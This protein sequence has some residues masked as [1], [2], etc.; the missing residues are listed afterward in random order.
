MKK[1]LI[2]L[3]SA[4]V[5]MLGG[6]S[7]YTAT[8]LTSASSTGTSASVATRGWQAAAPAKKDI[9]V[10]RASRVFTPEKGVEGMQKYIVRFDEEP[11]AMY[12]GDIPGLAATRASMTRKAG[13]RDAA[14]LDM[15][16]PAAEA[17]MSYLHDRHV[18]ME[19]KMNLQVGRKME[20]VYNYR[21]ALNGMTVRMTQDEAMELAKVPGIAKIQR[22][23]EGFLTT[24]R[25]PTYIGAPQIWD[26]SAT[27]L[28]AMG[29]GIVIGMMD[30]GINGDHPSFATIGADGYVHTN[31]LGDG[32]FLGECD[33]TSD[34]FNPEVVCTNK[35]IG[36]YLFIDANPTE[37]SSEDTDGHGTHTSSTAGGN[38]TRATVFDAEGSPTGLEL[39]ISGV[40]P[41]A[42]I[43]TFQVCAP[44]C[45][46][47]DRVAA[48]EQIISDGLV[49]V[50][51]HSIG[52][53]TPINSSP[54]EDAM[55]LSFLS[56]R[57][58]GITVA[59]SAGNNGPDA[60]TLGSPGAPW[61]THSGAFTHD[62]E[63]STKF[64]T[65]MTGGLSAPSDI[66][67][68]AVTGGYGP[69]P[70][71]YAG[72]FD[73]GDADPAQ[74][75][76]PFPAGTF[77]GE[78]VMCDRGAIARV[79]KC[80]NVRDGGAGG[81]I[82]ANVAGGSDSLNNDAHVLPAIHIDIAAGNAVRDWLAEGTD[83]TAIISS[84]L[85][86][87]GSNAA[88]AA[89]AA[90]F[91]SRGPNLSQ[92]YL[93]ITVGSPGVDVY[94][95]FRNGIEF[96]FLSG[97]SM[98]SPHTAGSSVLLKQL[99]PD[100]T[101]AEILSALATTASVAAMKEDGVTPADPFDVGGGMVQVAE[102]A[103]A[104]LLLDETVA[105][106]QAAD[107]A[108][109]GDPKALNLPGMVN[110]ECLI[111]CSWT[112]TFE[113][114]Q[115]GS[116]TVSASAANITV[117]PTTF[118]LV[119]GE[120]QTI[121]INVDASALAEGVW[122]HETVNLVPSSAALPEQHLTVSVLPAAGQIPDIIQATAVRNADS[123]VVEDITSIAI[124]DLQVSVSGLAPASEETFE[125]LGDS[126]NSSP[127]DDLTD[128]V[129]FSLLSVPAD[130]DLLV[131]FT[132]DETSE[133]PDL[134]LYVGLD[135]DGDGLPSAGELVC[136]SA[137]A[138]AS[139]TC[140]VDEPTEGTWWV[141]VQNW[142]ASA[143]PP[144]SFVLSTAVSAGDAGNL[145]VDAPF[146]VPALEPFDLRIIWNLPETAQPGDLFF[147][148]I[149]IGSD[150]DNPDNFGT[151]PVIITRGE[152][153][154]TF[155]AS[156]DIAEVGDSIAFSA[157]IQPNFTTE[158]R[159]YEITAAIPPGF[160]VV[161]GSVTEGGV[162]SGDSIV[163]TVEMPSL[164][165]AE[166]SYVAVTSEEDPA[167]AI[168]FA[169]S[170]AYTDLEAFGIF[171]DTTIVGDSVTFNAFPGQNFNFYG[172]SFVGGL[173]LTDDGF[174]FFESTAGPSPFI[175][176]AIPSS[177]EPNDLIAA[178]WRDMIIP[179]PSA[180]PGAVV[181]VSLATAGPD[182]TLIEFDNMEIWPGGL[183]DSI[184]FAVAI[185]GV[186]DDTP[187]VYEIMTAFD[188]VNV[189]ET[190]GT[191]GVEN[192]TGTAGTQVFFEDIAV[193]SGM[194]ICYDLVQ[195]PSD[196][197]VLSYELTVDPVAV[198]T[199]VVATLTSEVD[200]IG[201]EAVTLEAPISVEG[202][203]LP[204]F[205]G[206]FQ[207]SITST[208]PILRGLPILVEFELFDNG[209]ITTEPDLTFVVVD[210]D[211]DVVYTASGKTFRF[212]DTY[213]RL[214]P[215][216]RL[217]VGD[218]TIKA[219]VDDIVVAEE[220]FTIRKFKFFF[221]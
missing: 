198:G 117:S 127:F 64:M 17:Y 7:A 97:T 60:S 115:A 65:D 203:P 215:T 50:I 140:N 53:N 193:T 201:T 80:I 99:H 44:G 108:L 24:D 71:V 72:D 47:S 214:M 103:K 221:W 82:L 109:G 129:V 62:R 196:S 52:S 83:H 105:N 94:A 156:T 148:A 12:E 160:S 172:R 143:N 9:S 194:A 163:W 174:I 55:A 11:L 6:I 153:D 54:W 34:L 216:G 38:F 132:E 188:N 147:G 19:D 192:Q 100:W 157:E 155:T 78:I 154:V 191:I 166:P 86:Q 170:G 145:T 197:V 138:T 114:T 142:Q 151:I 57:A 95:A 178:L 171:P 70:V 84:N 136:V 199:D 144:D 87:F 137:S 141:L 31:P 165:N 89:I 56:A 1:Q 8:T 176:E 121:T 41:H 67:G 79:D 205:T 18:E 131:A 207:G 177:T 23:Y 96:S 150:A 173:S 133:S 13:N 168:P 128:G 189:T 116:W 51:N 68:R 69:A 59:N 39:N 22:D 104:G 88:N 85:Q 120:M 32:V 76:V 202:E 3:A 161:D 126:D 125:L 139:E 73:N 164:A 179:T 206:E 149:T 10:Q 49:D 118:S 181:G 90:D 112:R 63:I 219:V 211:G 15:H 158:D 92:D 180:T 5:L 81:C 146:S 26:G 98:A 77:N 107:P 14:R 213:F 204:V 220:E 102:A 74:C 42:N 40:A 169:N 123:F 16:T 66:E 186:V 58:A 111:E 43:I 187:G 30:S 135:T 2:T 182:L 159:T 124:T 167:C 20:V 29:E 106:F 4:S 33:P 152:D 101:D 212:S 113:A 36:R 91:T 200:V 46:T 195:P 210:E 21:V 75:L 45:A 183:G 110:R 185:S 217:P 190:F 61:I 28:D 175:N 37:D 209:I 184:D 35:L 162:V 25:G 27:G 119:P 130:A 93:P 122:A 48:V 134:D 208:R 218:L